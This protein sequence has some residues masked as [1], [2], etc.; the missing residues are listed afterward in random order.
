[1]SHFQKNNASDHLQREEFLTRPLVLATWKQ[2]LGT[3]AVD[4]TFL[5][6][7]FVLTVAVFLWNYPEVRENIDQEDSI[8]LVVTGLFY[9]LIYWILMEMGTG[10]TLGKFLFHTKVINKTGGKA[11]SGQIIAR[12]F[13][14][15]IPV[16]PLW[17]LG[18]DAPIGLHDRFS[19]T[20]VVRI[21]D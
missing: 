10:R 16:D 13:F 20:I 1:M 14:R 21:I 7:S 8:G 9:G 12:S 4:V 5:V 6:V 18:Q 15:F 2:R 11:S 17:Y 19:G 3:F